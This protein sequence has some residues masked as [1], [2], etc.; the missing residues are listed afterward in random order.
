MCIIWWSHGCPHCRRLIPVRPNNSPQPGAR[1]G[2]SKLPQTFVDVDKVNPQLPLYRL[3]LPQPETHEVHS[4]WRCYEVDTGMSLRESLSKRMEADM[5]N[6]LHL[7]RGDDS[8]GPVP[9]S[10]LDGGAG[11]EAG[12]GAGVAAAFEAG[13]GARLGPG[14]GPGSLGVA[15]EN[16][17][18]SLN[19]SS[20]LNQN[21]NILN[22]NLPSTG[23]NNPAILVTS[24]PVLPP[25]PLPSPVPLLSSIDNSNSVNNNSNDTSNNTSSSA[26]QVSLQGQGLPRAAQS[27]G[28][29][30]G[31][32]SPG[33]PPGFPPPVLHP[34][35]PPGPSSYAFRSHGPLLLSPVLPLFPLPSPSLSGFPI[36]MD[37]L[38]PNPLFTPLSG[39]F[40]RHFYGPLFSPGHGLDTFSGPNFLPGQGPKKG[41]LESFR[42]C[43]Y[44]QHRDASNPEK[45]HP[46]ESCWLTRDRKGKVGIVD[47]MLMS[48]R[49]MPSGAGAGAGA[50]YGQGRQGQGG[51]AGPNTRAVQGAKAGGYGA[52]HTGQVSGHAAR[53][54]IHAGQVSVQTKRGHHAGVGGHATST[55]GRSAAPQTAPHAPPHRETHATPNTTPHLYNSNDGD[56]MSSGGNGVIPNANPPPDQNQPPSQHQANMRVQWWKMGWSRLL[57]FY[58]PVGGRG[59]RLMMSDIDG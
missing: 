9:G 7:C 47:G 14:L 28:L 58:L 27:R 24:D 21:H 20:H 13:L 36:G 19:L 40:P 31:D 51:H 59:S 57:Q 30:R 48:P 52:M 2:S 6:G 55:H 23:P 18:L 29:P 15:P 56:R 25:A 17:Y 34:V 54:Q 45:S 5:A 43:P 12:P 41:G 1:A 44:L 46:P 39:S 8:V 35:L 10:I 22:L 3:A 38:L 53:G 4:I 26:S 49:P 50:G 32:L 42:H 37:S 33:L 16:P 11:A